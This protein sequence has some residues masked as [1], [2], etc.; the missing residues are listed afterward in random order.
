M[1]SNCTATIYFQLRQHKFL[2]SR[3]IF[4]FLSEELKYIPCIYTP[5]GMFNIKFFNFY[6][7]SG[8]HCLSFPRSTRAQFLGGKAAQSIKLLTFVLYQGLNVWSFNS[9]LVH[10][11]LPLQYLLM[12]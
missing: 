11:Y 12:P 4:H 7:A 10:I 3:Y 9:M 6:S 2:N 1:Q 8:P 5:T